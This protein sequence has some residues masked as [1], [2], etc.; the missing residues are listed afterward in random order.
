MKRRLLA[1][2]LLINLAVIL[3]GAL[4]ARAEVGM[5]TDRVKVIGATSQLYC[6][7]AVNTSSPLYCHDFKAQNPTTVSGPRYNLVPATKTGHWVYVAQVTA[8]L[9]PD[10]RFP[11][12]PLRWD[13]A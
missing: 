8:T 9:T 5:Y 6:A 10:A 4:P 2:V 11:G 13:S 7:P 12:H 3:A 1:A